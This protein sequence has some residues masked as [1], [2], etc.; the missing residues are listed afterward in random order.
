MIQKQ[1]VK[2]IFP[3]LYNQTEEMKLETIS[4]TSKK[5]KEKYLFNKIGF[6]NLELRKGLPDLFSSADNKSKIVNCYQM[7][8]NSRMEFGLPNR[9][10]EYMD[11]CCR[12]QAEETP[13]KIAITEVKIYLFESGVGFVEAEC[14]GKSTEISDLITSNYFLSERKTDDN[15]FSLKKIFLLFPIHSNKDTPYQIS[16]VI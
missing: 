16:T 12:G 7:E 1:F 2:V 3:F 10:D 5:G 4:V 8:P 6:D 9:S 13:Y 15:Y 14:V 11:F